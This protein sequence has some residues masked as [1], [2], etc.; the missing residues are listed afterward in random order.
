MKR[1]VEPLVRGLLENTQIFGPETE[2]PPQVTTALKYTRKPQKRRNPGDYGGSD[3]FIADIIDIFGF[4]PLKFQQTSWE[5][6]RDLNQQRCGGDSQGAIFSAPTGFG[7]TE[8]FLGPLYQLLR[9]D[10][11][12][13]VALV[14]PS[15]ALLQDQLGRVLEH[16]HTIK[17]TSEDQISVGV[18]SGDTAY[19]LDDVASEKALFEGTGPN[20]RFRL[21]N[22]W[23]GEPHDPHSFQYD[24]GSAHYELVCEHDDS[25]S[26]TE[27]EVVLNREDIRRSNGPE[28]VLTTLESL[29]LFGLKP[30][31]DLIDEI[32]AI[33]FDEIHLYTGIRGAHAANVVDN[34]ESI[35]DQ[36]MLW[37]GASATVDDAEQFAAKIFPIPDGRIEAVAPPDEDFETDHDDHEHYFFLKATEDGPGVSSMFI[38]QILLLGHA[39]LQ[40]QDGPRGKLL[41]FIDSISQVN[42]KR[43][44]LQDA[45]EQRELWRHHVDIDEPGDWRD[46]AEGMDR[47]FVEGSLEFSSVYSDA[48]FDASVIRS[49]V[50]LSTNFLEVGID[51]GDISIVTQYRT[52]WNLSSFVQRVGRAAREPGTDSFIFVFLSDLTS[53]SNMFYRADRFLGSE[54]RTPLK[55]DNEVI[56][57][58][59]DR[60]REFYEGSTRVRER[61][62]FSNK[63]E[64]EEFHEEYLVDELG[65]A[66]YYDLIDDPESVLFRTLGITG[67]FDPLVGQEPIM[68]V[69]A[70]LEER[71]EELEEKLDELG[72][73]GEEGTGDTE[74]EMVESVRTDILGYI[75]ERRK[76][77]A[78]CREMNE[79]FVDRSVLDGLESEL[80]EARE[81]IA[82]PAPGLNVEIDRFRNVLPILYTVK[83]NVLRVTNAAN[84]ADITLSP[85]T[86]DIGELESSIERIADALDDDRVAELVLERKR[87]YYLKQTLEELYDYQAIPS[88]Y[89]SLY[90][91][92]HLLRGG[93]YYDRFLQTAGDS[94]A[95][96]VWFVPENYFDDAGQYF[97]VFHGDDDVEGSDQSIDKIVHSYTPFRSEYK[98]DAGELQAFIPETIIYDDS[99]K[100]TFNDVSGERRDDLII[101]DSIRL[102]TVTDLS[103]SKALNIVRY[104]PQCL[105][106]LDH[107][108]C[109]R[110][111]DRALGKIHASPSVETSVNI[112]ENTES[113]GLVTLSDMSGEVKLVGVSLEITPATYI[114]S[115]DEYIFTG[116]DRIK[117]EIESPDRTLGF[118]LDT[119]GLT[120]DISRFLN[121]I[122][123]PEI[124]T[125]LDRYKDRSEVG[126]REMGAHTAAHF[127]IQLVADVAGVTPRSLFYGI[128]MDEEVV[129]VFE[130]SQGGQGLVDLVFDD[131]REDPG[132]ALES[133]TRIT[134]DPQ[135]ICERLWAD[136]SFVDDLPPVNPDQTAIEDA[137]RSADE[138][139]MFDHVVDQVVEE[140]QST[141][142]RAQQLAQEEAIS[143][144]RA[145]QIKNVVSSARI[146]G[147]STYPEEAVTDVLPDFDGHDR[148]ETLFFSPN[149]DGCVEN[150]Q[151][152]ECISGHD[153]S[154][155]LSYVLLEELREE[156]IQRVPHDEMAD[157]LFDREVLPGGEYDGTS[158]FLT[159]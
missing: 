65:W 103:G 109:L 11:L 51:V 58:I 95:D 30:N 68:E 96:E 158:I 124:V 127:F 82:E 126:L 13:R 92:K 132:T 146:D 7:K 73:A 16:L 42:Q 49:D 54:I 129:Y 137:V 67:S 9:E 81:T 27:E 89:L 125:R 128:D 104:C 76:L 90:Y 4:E 39:M 8:A 111:N 17:T 83:G 106:I 150:L 59:H 135:V 148:V 94:L 50:L 85:L 133:V 72:V 110:H 138:V 101:P 74:R 147:E 144:R 105:Q 19:E 79:E 122:D 134:Y 52:P 77:V 156:L 6:V 87:L 91:V 56:E 64:K 143:L 152:S 33:V 141:V 113:R 60:Y 120:F 159:L 108:S 86:L 48:G 24:G 139:P 145:F 34:I 155:T 151:L 88:N 21:A 140:V 36:S 45:D 23:C 35:T 61:R 15:K 18:W 154:D 31:Y 123:D 20:K 116:E 26:F 119:R 142:D 149:I 2:N 38:Q 121:R 37:L 80:E 118:G 29:E 84:S 99:V 114:R 55:P 107:G 41:S 63:R 136:V 12:E 43:T 69:L 1:D 10:D 100:F 3:P 14:Y 75:K 70:A 153:Q 57:W 62:H 40:Q 44:Q 98:Q 78:E 93:Y 66:E 47:E 157:E 22:C 117:R 71:D 5:L 130:R 102:D 53:D 25:H 97:T 32:D 28:I 46:V 131:L 115:S 112:G